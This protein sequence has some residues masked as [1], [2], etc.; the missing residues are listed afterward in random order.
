MEKQEKRSPVEGKVLRQAGESGRERLQMIFDERVLLVM[1]FASGMWAVIVVEWV[2]VWVKWPLL[3]VMTVAATI[4]TGYLVA[5]LLEAIPQIRNL[6]LGADGETAVGQMLERLRPYGYEVFH[7]ID[8]GKGNID[9]VVVGRGGVFAIE[10]KTRSKANGEQEVLWDGEK[11]HIDGA[12][13]VDEPIRQ[14][15]AE[16][17][18]LRESIQKA[19]GI[20]LEI[21][22][23]LVYP[24]WF[25]RSVSDCNVWV[26]D[27]KGTFEWLAKR[28][29]R[30]GQADA[31][32]I[33]GAVGELAKKR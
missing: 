7:D 15:R 17:A 8:S 23:I 12:G 13:Y 6:K 21:Q 22:G 28:F 25:T 10:T 4:V 27:D 11:L 16:A 9:H 30:I 20:G 1:A 32:R 26:L 5:K 18:Y 19:T 31:G 29:P 3:G 24:G 2:G 14:V 33:A